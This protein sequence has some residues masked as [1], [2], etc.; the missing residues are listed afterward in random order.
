[1][2]P[3]LDLV[4]P[5]AEPI[6]AERGAEAVLAARLEW[7]LDRARLRRMHDE[8]ARDTIVAIE[9]ELDPH[10]PA[11]ADDPAARPA[12][13]VDRRR[14]APDPHAGAPARGH[15]RRVRWP[16]CRLVHPLTHRLQT[17]CCRLAARKSLARSPR[18]ATRSGGPTRE[19]ADARPEHPGI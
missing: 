3:P 1:V 12:P 15:R 7:H 5:G 18:P 13:A 8:H 17:A 2:D 14:G 10:L 19:P 16:G 9:A 4:A 11:I 6:D